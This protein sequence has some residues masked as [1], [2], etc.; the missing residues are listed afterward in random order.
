MTPFHHTCMRTQA[1]SLHWR[2]ALPLSS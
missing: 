2:H 1:F